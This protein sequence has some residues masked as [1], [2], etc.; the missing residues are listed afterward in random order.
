MILCC[1]KHYFFFLKCYCP[2][3]SSLPV[4]FPLYFLHPRFTD[5]P[6]NS[7]PRAGA[8]SR[9]LPKQALSVLSQRAPS[10]S[11]RAPESL[12]PVFKTYRP[13]Y[14]FSIPESDALGRTSR[15]VQGVLE[16][17]TWLWWLSSHPRYQHCGQL[18]FTQENGRSSQP[19]SCWLA[20]LGN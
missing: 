14:T 6:G 1:I 9:A 8:R 15:G 18:Q 19:W 20:G 13:D 12:A 3:T 11:V 5:Q 16:H 2:D 17:H 10:G 7:H 4:P